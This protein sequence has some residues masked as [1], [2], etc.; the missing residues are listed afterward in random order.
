MSVTHHHQALFLNF[1]E[2]IS[3]IHVTIYVQEVYKYNFFG[4]KYL[5][6]TPKFVSGEGSKLCGAWFS[7]IHF[8]HRTPVGITG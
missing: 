4:S 6:C 3:Q 2:E 8:P 1:S 7:F 5:E